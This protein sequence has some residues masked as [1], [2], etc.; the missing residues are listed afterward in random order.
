M[1]CYD[2]K[3][4]IK[5]RGNHPCI[6]QWETFNE[7]DCWNVFKDAPNDVAGIVK[8][9]QTLDPTRLV[10]TDSGGGANNMHIGDVNDIHSYPQ[11]GDPKASATQYGMIGEFGGIGAF[12]EGKEWQPKACHH[13]PHV[14]TPH[15]E[16]TAYVARA[17]K[18]H[19]R[20]NHAYKRRY[21]NTN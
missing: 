3:A 13:N 20:A 2:L 5:G 8:L 7:G 11:P 16:E 21:T 19:Q 4:M 17:A 9:A 14:D 10:D 1:L 18:T 15:D 12:V 6:V